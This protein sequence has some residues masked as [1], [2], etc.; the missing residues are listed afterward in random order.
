LKDTIPD[1]THLRYLLTLQLSNN[2]LTGSIPTFD[3]LNNIVSLELE[4]NHLKGNIPNFKKSPKLTNLYLNYNQLSGEIP[5]FS[6]TPQLKRIY[7]AHNLLEGTLPHFTYTSEL[8]SISFAQNKLTGQIPKLR[9]LKNLQHINLSSNSLEGALPSFKKMK[10][11]RQINFSNNKLTGT[12]SSFKN[13]DL[14]E[15]LLLSNN[16]FT[17]CSKLSD[18]L[19]LNYIL[20]NGNQLNFREL[21][22][23]RAYLGGPE[24]YAHQRWSTHDSLIYASSGD[25]LIIDLE[26][27]PSPDNQYTW[28]LDGEKIAAP[29]EPFIKIPAITTAQSGKYKCEITNRH[30]PEMVLRTANF[31]VKLEDVIDLEELTKITPLARDDQFTFP[32]NTTTLIFDVVE[33]DVLSGLDDWEITILNEPDV[34]ILYNLDDGTIKYSIPPGFYGVV[35]FEYALTNIFNPQRKTTATVSLQIDPTTDEIQQIPNAIS[36]NGDGV[37]DNFIVP[38]LEQNPDLDSEIVIFNRF[39]HTVFKASPYLNNWN[40]ILQTNGSAL[41]EGTYFYVLKIAGESKDFSGFITVKR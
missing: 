28:F 4:F 39:G 21:D 23:N 33:N 29:N 37:N 31:N 9:H 16:K 12:I 14:L 17:S 20:L 5:S 18:K 40:G 6:H 27:M 15:S 36:P 25:S 35:T 19:N 38:A 7:A 3:R 22:K 24:T 32:D 26:K 2:Q 34:G 30:Y 13:S 10:A 8:I 11:L 1:F 41:P